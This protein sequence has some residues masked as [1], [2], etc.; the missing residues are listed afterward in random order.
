MIVKICSSSRWIGFLVNFNTRKFVLLLNESLLSVLIKL[1]LKSN[2]DSPE[3]IENTSL[4]NVD[5]LLFEKEI[6][7]NFVAPVNASNEIEVI[8]L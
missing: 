3:S 6:S 8:S 7:F 5:I 2:T 4:F 1:L